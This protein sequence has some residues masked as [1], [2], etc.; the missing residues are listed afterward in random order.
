MIG[1]REMLLAMPSSRS[2]CRLTL[3]RNSVAILRRN[4]WLT[5]RVTSSL[6]GAGAFSRPS[7]Y[8]TWIEI[9]ICG[10]CG[11]VAHRQVKVKI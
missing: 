2:L 5:S 11:L 7:A 8:R 6:F 3:P 9:Q 1:D 4:A 10:R